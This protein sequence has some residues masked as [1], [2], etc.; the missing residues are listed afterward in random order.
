MSSQEVCSQLHMVIMKAARRTLLDEIVSHAISECITEKKDLKKATNQKKVT[1]QSVKM[2]SPGTRMSAGF[3]GSKALIDPERG[4]EAPNFLNRK[5]PAA[6]IPLKSSG[7]SKSVGS[8]LTLACKVSGMLPSMTMFQS[9]HL[10][11]GRENDGHLLT[12]NFVVAS[13]G[14]ILSPKLQVEKESFGSDPDYPPGFEEKDMTVDNPSVSSSKDCTAELSTEVL[15][16]E[17]ES[18]CCDLDFPPGFE[19]KNMTVDLP[20]VS[21]P[22]NDEKVLSRSS[23]ATDPEANDRM[24]PILESI[25]DELHLSAKMSLEEYFI[26]LLH[27]EVMGKVDS[28]KDGMIIKVA[29]YPNIFNGGASQNDSSEVILVSENL[30]HVDIQNTS[31]RKKSLHQNSIDPYVISLPDWFSSAFQKSADLDNASS[32]G[33]TDELQPPD[34]EA[35]PVQTSKVRLARSDDSILRIIW[36]AT[37]SNYRQRVHEKVLRELNT[38]LLYLASSILR[39]Q[40]IS[41]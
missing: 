11:G 28:L 4:A 25:L 8:Y 32:N 10:R 34:C 40:L 12:Y 36:Y 35:V 18:F 41:G 1:N 26:C 6:E 5:S 38:K 22:F 9:I 21:S 15:Q 31:S 14:R 13:G 17:K 20:S 19:E 16:V 27:E 29:E 30:A 3:G 7:S 39:V 24:Q 2:S 23:H 33:T 37:L